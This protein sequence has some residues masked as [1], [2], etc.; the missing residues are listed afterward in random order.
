MID[1]NNGQ[2]TPRFFEDDCLR[3]NQVSSPIFKKNLVPLCKEGKPVFISYKPKSKKFFS[4]YD[5]I[6]SK[7]ENL[8]FISDVATSYKFIENFKNKDLIETAFKIDKDRNINS[9]QTNEFIPNNTSNNFHKFYQTIS[10][11][12]SNKI[13]PSL[14][15]KNGNNQINS[16]YNNKQFSMTQNNFLPKYARMYNKKRINLESTDTNQKQTASE[17]NK[18]HNKT[19]KNFYSSR[20]NNEVINKNSDNEDNIDLTKI[21]KKQKNQIHDIEFKFDNINHINTNINDQDF[22]ISEKTNFEITDKETKFFKKYLKYIEYI[23]KKRL[24]SP[25]N[26]KE[27]LDENNKSNYPFSANNL[28]PNI[29]SS[30]NNGNYKE[31]QT[32]KNFNK[33]NISP[34]DIDIVEFRDAIAKSAEIVIDS[35]KNT[36]LF[37]K[38]KNFD[39]EKAKKKIFKEI[40]QNKI[41]EKLLDK[42]FRKVIYVSDKNVEI[43]EDFVVN[44]IHNEIGQL[45]ARNTSI[46]SDQS[47]LKTTNGLKTVNLPPIV[48]KGTASSNNSQYVL[49]ENIFSERGGTDGKPRSRLDLKGTLSPI[50]EIELDTESKF[51]NINGSFFNNNTDKDTKGDNNDLNE[52][53][54]TEDDN[55]GTLI[56][57]KNRSQFYDNYK[58][59]FQQQYDEEIYIKNNKKI[60][61]LN[62][63]FFQRYFNNPKNLCDDH[64]DNFSSKSE[65]C[66]VN[67]SDDFKELRKKSDNNDKEIKIAKRVNSPKLDIFK[68]KND[69]NKNQIINYFNIDKKEKNI[70]MFDLRKYTKEFSKKENYV[71]EVQSKKNLNQVKNTKKFK[72]TENNEDDHNCSANGTLNSDKDSSK[73][74]K[75]NLVKQNVSENNQ[76]DGNKNDNTK[77]YKGYGVMNFLGKNSAKG[78]F[79]NNNLNSGLNA[80]SNNENNNINNNSNQIG[81]STNSLLK[82]NDYNYINNDSRIPEEKEP[83][84]T[85]KI[86]NKDK[87]KK[88]NQEKTGKAKDDK[89][90]GNPIKKKKDEKSKKGKKNS[91]DMDENEKKEFDEENPGEIKINSNPENNNITTSK[92][93][94]GKSLINPIK[95][96]NPSKRESKKSL[97]FVKNKFKN[98]IN[99]KDSDG[100]DI[101]NNGEGHNK[102]ISKIP[103]GNID[104]EGIVIE[105]D[106]QN[107][108]T[109][110]FDGYENNS[111]SNS[112]D[113]PDDLFKL[114]NDVFIIIFIKFSY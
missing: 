68:Y 32:K 47:N 4:N 24:N 30:A 110:N 51:K 12:N 17:R 97:N 70:M 43:C 39:I 76:K 90:K 15:D 22:D 72:N 84:N 112:N 93:D 45:T 86:D 108:E 61:Y 62:N 94:S 9:C 74:I 99:L 79:N 29:L 36:L 98:N 21:K 100:N 107:F 20:E 23:K 109:I 80:N 71:K 77:N 65:R 1:N 13:I 58:N 3:R 111:E 54:N 96:K 49:S 27:V 14:H 104:N 31:F 105:A 106:S 83:D 44:L 52:I 69:F 102:K 7:K 60:N 87:N 113:L 78:Y 88:N 19:K 56:N 25:E 89:K 11:F 48:K 82:K 59:N 42:V 38:D 37:P 101:L 66:S 81:S 103:Y 35:L 50:G 6:N 26:K 28:R 53:G 73:F 57:G 63:K 33:I 85:K 41:F 67:Y 10:N 8:Q 91:T 5:Q 64:F 34:F 114:I 16:N 2:V 75:S 55:D 40:G 18:N 95:D 92:L 46:L